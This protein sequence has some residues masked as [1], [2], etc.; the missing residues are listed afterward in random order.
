MWEV[1][2]KSH[3]DRPLESQVGVHRINAV[4]LALVDL[5]SCAMPSLLQR[6]KIF[7]PTGFG[8]LLITCLAAT[9]PVNGT[10]CLLKLLCLCTSRSGHRLLTA[11]RRGLTFH[12]LSALVGSQGVLWTG[13]CNTLLS[14]KNLFKGFESGIPPW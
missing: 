13:I 8:L 10:I 2:H 4:T 14:L 7:K 12:N 5:K 1:L 6:T 3:H 11:S 9:L